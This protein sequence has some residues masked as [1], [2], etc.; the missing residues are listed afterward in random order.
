MNKNIWN[1][2]IDE[3]NRIAFYT[4]ENILIDINNIYLDELIILSNYRTR[5]YKFKKNNNNKTIS[6]SKYLK[7]Q[8]GSFTNFLD[9][10]DRFMIHID[11]DNKKI[12]INNN[13]HN[14]DKKN[15]WVIVN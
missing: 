7:S 3:I 15:E 10:Y 1:K 13:I 6:L 2:S 8:H 9:S 14:I 12:S 11:G 5:K 4:I